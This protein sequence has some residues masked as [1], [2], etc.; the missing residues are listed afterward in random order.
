MEG[1]QKETICKYILEQGNEFEGLE[2]KPRLT[3]RLRDKDFFQSYVQE[4]NFEKLFALDEKQIENEARL[5]I[6]RNS[7]VLNSKVINTF[8]KDRG[9]SG[10]LNNTYK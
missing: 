6:K 8:G 1:N 2:P 4:L 7:Q 10:N 9:G 3:L 5:N